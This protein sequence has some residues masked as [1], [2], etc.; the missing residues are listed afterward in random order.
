MVA[1]ALLDHAVLDSPPRATG[2]NP[3]DAKRNQL[4]AAVG[5]TPARARLGKTV[6]AEGT[7]SSVA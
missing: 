3:I 7:K 4:Q 5:T 6:A 2:P 1:A